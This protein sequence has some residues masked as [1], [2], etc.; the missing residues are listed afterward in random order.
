MKNANKYQTVP[1]LLVLWNFFDV[2]IEEA[3]LYT[4]EFVP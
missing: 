3:Q 1:L 4:P 2:F